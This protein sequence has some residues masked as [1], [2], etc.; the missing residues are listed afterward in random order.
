MPQ[1]ILAIF[2]GVVVMLSGQ[3]WAVIIDVENPAVD[4]VFFE[5]EM[6][7]RL[8]RDIQA[9]LGH[10]RFILGIDFKLSSF[11][12]FGRQG[13]DAGDSDAGDRVVVREITTSLPGLPG[14]EVKFQKE[15]TGEDINNLRENLRLDESSLGS[16]S[17]L[18]SVLQPSTQS[19]NAL[20]GTGT[21]V[22]LVL[23]TTVTTAQE[24]FIRDV[25]SRKLSIDLNKGDSI[26]IV[27]STFERES[28]S[29]NTSN[30]QPNQFGENPAQQPPLSGNQV[31][32]AGAGAPTTDSG[33]VS[34]SVTDPTLLQKI[35]ELEQGLKKDFIEKNLVWILLGGFGFLLFFSLILFLASRKPAQSMMPAYPPMAPPQSP[36]TGASNAE[37]NN[38]DQIEIEGM[39]H[40]AVVAETKREIAA[41]GLASPNIVKQE[42][43]NLWAQ[44][45]MDTIAAVYTG[46][47]NSIYE[48]L[49][50]GLSAS[51][52]SEISAYLSEREITSTQLEAQVKDFYSRSLRAANDPDGKHKSH[53]FAFL[54]KMRIGS[55]QFLLKN[56]KPRVKALVISQLENEKATTVLNSFED[57]DRSKVVHELAQFEDFPYETFNEVAQLLVRKAK[58]I[59][60]VNNVGANGINILINLLDN[61]DSS[62]ESRLIEELQNM[63]PE[64]HD[65]LK[66]LYF[67]FN[68]LSKAPLRVMGEALLE[69]DKSTI[70]I[71]LMQAS[72]VIRKRV[73]SSMPK[74][75][76]QTIEVEIK[77]IQDTIKN[78][79]IQS[80]RKVLLRSMRALV[81]NGKIDMSKI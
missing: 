43:N 30:Q 9:Y 45:R 21:E 18:S 65:K 23:D 8:S 68:D 29:S 12:G 50:G 3:A 46:L 27:R 14:A 79:Q 26:Q 2:I 69:V 37:K 81:R 39:R 33:N 34:D 59:P 75:V 53:S 47:G 67:T 22:F 42:M 31:P 13:S 36:R 17:P 62:D 70:A 51:Q 77:E 56:E 60:A 10:D 64:L 7:S 41:I 4:E 52:S 76:S 66:T 55:L 1:N 74:R 40:R 24:N 80:A 44:N 71:A 38:V 35:N 73:L 5:K 57:K 32:V 15:L 16:R 11:A 28:N 6:E 58:K 49:F 72:D 19:A 48:S 78:E 25:M 20:A 54:N 61:M 63:D